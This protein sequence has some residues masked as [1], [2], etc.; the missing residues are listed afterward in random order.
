M[1]EDVWKPRLPLPV[2]YSAG[3]DSADKLLYGVGRNEEQEFANVGT[4]LTQH[5]VTHQ[6][7]KTIGQ[8]Y[9]VGDRI[10]KAEKMIDLPAGDLTVSLPNGDLR[11]PGRHLAGGDRIRE[12]GS[13]SGRGESNGE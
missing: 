7:A 2:K 5:E 3:V 6:H 9:S 11:L 1:N 10:Q 12:A 8:L 13:H 4:Q